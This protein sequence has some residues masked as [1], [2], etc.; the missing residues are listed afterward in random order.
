MECKCT[1]VTGS[2]RGETIY[3]PAQRGD[4]EGFHAVAGDARR[5][6][7]HSGTAARHRKER[8]IY[9][10]EIATTRCECAVAER[11]ARI[12]SG[13]WRV[14]LAACHAH[15]RHLRAL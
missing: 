4:T 9:P 15:H 5:C 14:K 6:E 1:R 10:N 3:R 2:A 7:G 8:C 12:P 13:L 11:R